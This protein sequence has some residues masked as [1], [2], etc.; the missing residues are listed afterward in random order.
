MKQILKKQIAAHCLTILFES[1]AALGGFHQRCVI[2]IKDKLIQNGGPKIH[3]CC[4]FL[5]VQKT[6]ERN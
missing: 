3:F 1:Q 4:N 6:G 2:L 5:F